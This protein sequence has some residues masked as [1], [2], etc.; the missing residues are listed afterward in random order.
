MSMGLA[1][2]ENCYKSRRELP[3]TTDHCNRPVV[4]DFGFADKPLPSPPLVDIIEHELEQNEKGKM[5]RSNAQSL[6]LMEG[7]TI[8]EAQKILM[9][10]PLNVGRKFPQNSVHRAR[11]LSPLPEHN[12]DPNDQTRNQRQLML[13]NHKQPGSV[14]NVRLAAGARLTIARSHS[15][16]RHGPI[17]STTST[18][19]L[20]SPYP[21]VWWSAL[22]SS[23]NENAFV[24]P[25][26][27]PSPPTKKG[28][29]YDC[30]DYTP[31]GLPNAGP[32]PPPPPRSLDRRRPTWPSQPICEDE[33]AALTKEIGTPRQQGNRA[34]GR[35]VAAK[36][37]SANKCSNSPRSSGSSC[38]AEDRKNSGKGRRPREKLQNSH[39]EF[40][41]RPRS[42]PR[43]SANN[44][45]P[46]LSGGKTH[47]SRTWNGVERDSARVETILEENPSHSRRPEDPNPV[48]LHQLPRCDD[49]EETGDDNS[50]QD[51]LATEPN[52]I[53]RAPIPQ[54]DNSILVTKQTSIT[55]H[56]QPSCLR[57]GGYS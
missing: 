40:A 26:R 27:A 17:R 51:P 10:P 28:S 7:E 21:R 55:H 13:S 33:A 22:A 19:S 45:N 3:R 49:D 42:L 2:N 16:P 50:I 37:L 12:V 30:S 25:R 54:P 11:S 38:E 32:T 15:A 9:P 52:N 5:G 34:G 57:G 53:R 39:V 4:K 46:A 24:N 48:S 1:E 31:S 36:A 18:P 56:H 6:I 23:P 35:A 29:K 14:R 20:H 44:S 8:E 47:I 43:S 41:P